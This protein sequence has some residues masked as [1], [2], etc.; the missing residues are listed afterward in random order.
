MLATGPLICFNRHLGPVSRRKNSFL[1]RYRVH[2][3]DTVVMSDNDG[4]CV[5]TAH[6]NAMAVLVGRY[7]IGKLMPKCKRMKLKVSRLSYLSHLVHEMNSIL[8]SSDSLEI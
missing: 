4:M 5:V 6:V 3:C 8:S 1:I 2:H 7:F